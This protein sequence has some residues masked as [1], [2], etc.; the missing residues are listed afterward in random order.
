VGWSFKIGRI[1]GTELRVH[2][3]FFLLLVWIGLSYYASGGLPAAIQG[4]IF[5][6]LIFACVV[7]HEFGHALAAKYF[8]GIE[9]PDITL[10]PIGGVARLQRMP[11]KPIG[12]LVVAI[13]GPL[14]NVVIALIL[15]ALL[16]RLAGPAE[17][18]QMTDPRANMLAKLAVLNVWLV[19]FNLIPAFPMDGGRILR[20]ILALSLS[21]ARATRIAAGIGQTLAF[22][23]GLLGLM[24]WNP[25]LLLIAVFVYLGASQESQMA[26][27]RDLSKGLAVSDAMI[28]RFSTLPEDAKLE[29]AIKALMQTS[30]HEFPIVGPA[31]NVAGVLTRDRIIAALGKS[32][33][34][35]PVSEVMH[36]EIP[37]VR[38]DSNFDTAFRTM[39]EC[40]CP[41]LPVLDR[42]GKLVGLITP[43]NVGELMMISS[44]L[45][46]GTFPSWREVRT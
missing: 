42:F 6:L 38:T 44:V 3:T 4:I 5:I 13:A 23:F 36:R 32:G 1:A 28:T 10:L 43:E 29:D 18:Q 19:L 7:L 26:Q 15:F 41:A 46:D 37:T 45:P 31:G 2:A 14:V 20:S 40:Q 22:V 24:S 17:V 25:M 12:E 21:Y 9:T 33:P 27:L 35:T 34:S 8:Y 39:Q 16:G 11:D 30:Q